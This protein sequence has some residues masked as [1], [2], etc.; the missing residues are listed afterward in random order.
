MKYPYFLTVFL[1]FGLLMMR[2]YNGFALEKQMVITSDIQY[3][4][5]EKLF[6][7]NDYE[8]AIVE[9]KRFIHF[10]PD[11]YQVDQAQFK[12]GICLFNLKKFHG[13]AKIFNEIIIKDKDNDI[14]KESSFYQS[15]A[16]LNLGNTGYAQIVL[17]NYLKLVEDEE[18]KD[19]ICFNLAL[20][21]LT[22][23][24]NG[25]TSSLGLA[26]TYLS[27]ISGPGAEKYDTDQ[28]L[29]LIIKT[30]ASPRKNPNLAGLF[31]VVPGGGFLYCERYR[32]AF[33]SFLLNTGLIYAAD[34]AYDND[35]V[36]LAGV[37]GFVGAGFY[38]GNIYGSISS[39]H[40][41]N[42]AQTIKLLDPQFS[43]RPKFDLEKNGYGLSFHYKF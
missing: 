39:A 8:T 35:N 4:Y 7:E 18:T 25:K 9:F 29:D 41:Y 12:I 14:T 23:A 40:K 37:I 3:G 20:I 43:I 16:F 28:Y 13:A 27:K 10:F 42:R 22:E 5:A 15:K 17:Q 6:I 32:D 33:V 2:P 31:A 21:H 36:A 1:I 24:R 19:R 26:R 38:T 34:A 30:E 11:S